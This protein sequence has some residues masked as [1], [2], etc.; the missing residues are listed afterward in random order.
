MRLLR[1]PVRGLLL[2]V[3]LLTLLALLPVLLLRRRSAGRE[4]RDASGLIGK[5]EG[6]EQI[7]SLTRTTAGRTVLLRERRV[8]QSTGFRH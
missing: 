1:L 6:N 4:G 8:E 5:G 3:L 7:R 2:T